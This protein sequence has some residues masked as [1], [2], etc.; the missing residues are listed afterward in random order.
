MEGEE[1]ISLRADEILNNAKK[2]FAFASDHD[3]PNLSLFGSDGCVMCARTLGEGFNV[4]SKYGSNM[5]QSVS[6][7][8]WVFCMISFVYAYSGCMK[9]R[10]LVTYVL[11]CDL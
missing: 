10:A 9:E 4:C 5:F 6:T 1:Q 2:V 11:G 7:K 8:K 3:I